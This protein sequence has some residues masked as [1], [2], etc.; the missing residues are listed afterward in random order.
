MANLVLLLA[1]F[2][3]GVVARRSR[4]FPEDSHKAVN[5]WVMLVSLPALVFRAIHGAALEPTLLLGAGLLWVVFLLPALL[6]W[7]RVTRG[8][9]RELGAVALCAGLGNT[10]FV[11]LPLIEA[12][13][14]KEALGAAAV[15]DQLGTFG[16]MFL[17]AI[18]WAT[19]LG[20]GS[21]SLGKTLLRVLRAP[22][23][24]ALVLALATRTLAV[25]GPVET[26]VGRLA[27]MLSPL[28]LASVGWQLD[29]S[30][31]RGNGKRIA[32]GLAWKL[33]LAPALVLGVLWLLRGHLGLEER[34]VVAQAAMA[35]MVTA[36]VIAADHK[37]APALAAALIAVGVPLS[38]VTVPVWWWAM[39]PGL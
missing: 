37:L 30:A 12:L 31:I 27:D 39:G 14:G 7:W 18:P 32:V 19:A 8:A 3:L 21:A 4:A 29:V 36:G 1:C 5:A 17:L 10:A 15:V 25:P 33:A 35:P 13:A 20:G 2:V 24:I 16:A 9:S 11:G 23:F 34:V 38:M 28:A 26:V 22:A 6:V